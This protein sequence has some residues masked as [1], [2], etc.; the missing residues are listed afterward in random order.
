VSAERRDKLLVGTRGDLDHISPQLPE[1]GDVF[2]RRINAEGERIERG[3]AQLVLTLVELV[4]QLLERQALRRVEG[5]TLSDDEVERLGTALMQLEER[6]EELKDEFALGDEDLN[7][8]LGPIG[9]L[10]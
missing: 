2:P 7:L 4:R 9:R 5:G 8:E 3:L 10:L 6:M 1:V